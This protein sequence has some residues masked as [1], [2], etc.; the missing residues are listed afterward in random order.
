[1][2]DAQRV[3]RY[4]RDC[5][6]ADN[7]GAIVYDLKHS[8]VRHFHWLDHGNE[9]LAG[10]LDSIPLAQKQAEKARQE[11]LVYKG[12][13]TLMLGGFT[14]L[15]K[16]PSDLRNSDRLLAPLVYYPATIHEDDTH[17]FIHANLRDQRINTGVLAELCNQT[18]TDTGCIDEFL[19]RFPAAPFGPIELESIISL[20]NRLF[21]A[22]CTDELICFP[23]PLAVRRVNELRKKTADQSDLAICCLPNSVMALV[24]NSRGTR[25]VLVDLKEISA[26]EKHSA[27]IAHLFDNAATGE[28]KPRGP[29]FTPAILSAAQKQ[30]FNSVHKHPLTLMAG[31]P[32]TGKSYTVAALALDHVIHG[33]SVLIASK[34]DQALDVV[35]DKLKML[36]GDSVPILRGGRSGYSK[37][38]KRFLKEVLSGMSHLQGDLK[39]I[40]EILDLK[41][42]IE[43]R[44]ELIRRIESNLNVRSVL[45]QDWGATHFG[46]SD[47]EWFM[48]LKHSMEN[49]WVTQKIKKRPAYSSAISFY[50]DSLQTQHAAIATWLR[51]HLKHRLKEALEKHRDQLVALNKA[52]RS[53]TQTNQEQW[54]QSIDLPNLLQVFPVWMVN[55]SD[56]NDLLPLY[57]EMFDLV[58][59]D[60]ATQCDLASCLPVFQRAKKAVITGDPKQLRHI[61]FL[62]RERQRHF[63]EHWDLTEEHQETFDYRDKSILDLL[64]E[65]AVSQEQI[66]M[67]DEHYR[68]RPSIIRF[69]NET[70]YERRLKVMTERPRADDVPAVMI[71]AVNGRRC[72]KG[73]NEVEAEKLIADVVELVKS[74][75][76]LT[77]AL[78]H[79]I[80][81]LSPFR[82][83]ADRLFEL[84]SNRISTNSLEKH[85]IRIGTPHA[86]Q[87][88]ERDVMFLSFAVDDQSHAASHRYLNRPD[89]FNV[90]IT[91]ARNLQNVYTSI[92]GSNSNGGSLLE[93][94]L[95]QSSTVR[96]PTAIPE[97]DRFLQ[98]VA[99]A[100]KNRG[101]HTWSAFGMAGLTMDLVVEK[102]G[103]LLAIDLIGCPGPYADSLDL[104]KYR[105]LERAGLWVFPLAWSAWHHDE[106]LCLDQIESW[107]LGTR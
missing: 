30:V 14:L 41:Q 92:S 78:C 70:F 59:I 101:Y 71:L 47:E 75:E 16:L 39:P 60:E 63:A 52:V 107:I 77:P 10:K 4:L 103:M 66:V 68:S 36:V 85:R 95:N 22:I 94:Y 102:S 58:I 13:M 19:R 65:R 53:R 42:S 88:D 55:L 76:S 79:S 45:E 49:W 62:A 81:I 48:R 34:G 17:G 46:K 24:P 11:A 15:G 33:R 74:Q 5:H 6:E 93:N 31:P 100:L 27:P 51:A 28:P 73:V 40:D 80:G 9:L 20:L 35:S 64:T 87:G 8:K 50:F 38:L 83:Q 21:P 44:D 29:V 86:F 69:S 7:R 97:E 2:T 106:Q 82:D 25:G 3:I 56:A 43:D 26:Q 104:E 98:S 72:P 61:S 12:E 99:T 67:L 18:G 84:L 91:R 32:G 90:S 37:E 57:C 23:T 1:M 54:Y 89:V 105:M 96:P